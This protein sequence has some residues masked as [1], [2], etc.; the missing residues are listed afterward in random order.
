MKRHILIGW[1]GGQSS[2]GA[3]ESLSLSGEGGASG[4]GWGEEKLPPV[5]CMG[6][7]VGAPRRPGCVRPGGRAGAGRRGLSRALR[8]LATPV[9]RRARDEVCRRKVEP[10]SCPRSGWPTVG[11]PVSYNCA[12]EIPSCSLHRLTS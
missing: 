6:V 8:Q 2:S 7:V 3:I 4:R 1:H 10:S 5:T 12:S 11:L 9:L